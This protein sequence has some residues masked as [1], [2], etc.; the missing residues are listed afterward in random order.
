MP[1][2]QTFKND[3]IQKLIALYCVISGILFFLAFSDLNESYLYYVLPISLYYIFESYFIFRKFSLGYW[4]Y[5]VGIT[6]PIFSI[7]IANSEYPYLADHHS[8]PFILLFLFSFCIFW[9]YYLNLKKGSVSLFKSLFAMC[10]VGIIGIS[11]MSLFLIF[12]IFALFLQ[13]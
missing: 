6:F 4:A 7:A 9:V 10:F 3:L 11:I 5:V 12:F 13:H 2:V 8:Q 1:T